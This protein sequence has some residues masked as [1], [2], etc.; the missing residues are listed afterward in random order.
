MDIVRIAR[1]KPGSDIMARV[2][3]FD[4]CVDEARGLCARLRK[5]RFEATAVH[6][7]DF[8]LTFE[9]T[10]GTPDVLIVELNM[11]LFSGYDL[12][13]SI[14]GAL[15]DRQLPIIVFTRE[16]DSAAW[17]LARSLGANEI[18]NR[19]GQDAMLRLDI[20]IARCLEHAGT[21]DSGS[22]RPHAGFWSRLWH[23]PAQPAAAAA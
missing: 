2:L 10:G 22:G 7:T 19:G 6:P 13:R 23:R 16:Q 1:P 8:D 3:V 15:S 4:R 17:E 21:A 20:A 12:I 18:V 5:R 14:R 9:E 11:P